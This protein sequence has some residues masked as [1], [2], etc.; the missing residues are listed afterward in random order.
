MAPSLVTI[1]ASEP[2]GKI[3]DVIVRDGGVII[4]NLLSPELL[5]ETMDA[6]TYQKKHLQSRGA[7]TNGVQQL[8]PI[9][10][11]ASCTTQSQLKAN[12]ALNSFPPVRSVFM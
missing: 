11:A 9:S 5:K 1:D 3:L 10:S 7:G 12:S 6:S 4:A 8:S 2:L